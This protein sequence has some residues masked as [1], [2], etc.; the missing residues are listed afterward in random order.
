MRLPQVRRSLTC[1]A[2]VGA[3]LP[4]LARADEPPSWVFFADR[5]REP[6]TLSIALEQRTHELAPRALRRRQRVRGDSGVDARDLLPATAYVDAVLA[7]GATL[8]RQSRWLNAI[9]VEA[10][11][12]QR[13]AIAALSAVARVQPVARRS[14]LED[15]RTLGQTHASRSLR[16]DEEMYG[17]AWQQLTA[18]NVPFLHDC[19]LTGEGVVIGVQDSGFSLE[20]IALQGV[21]VLA[22]RDFVMNDEVVAEEPGDA[23]GQHTHGTMVLSTIAGSDPGT[24]MGA[25]PG[26]S[27]LLSKTEDIATEQPFEEDNYVAGLEWLEM[28]GA[29]LFTASLGYLDWYEQSDFDGKTAVTTIAA[30][31]AVAQGLIMFNSIGNS[32]PGPT[33]MG[34]PADAEGVISVG[35]VTLDGVVTEFS[36]RGPTADGRIKPNIVAPGLDVAVAHPYNP[37]EYITAKGTSFSGPLAAGT[38]ALLL[39]AFPDATPAQ[40]RA[41]LQDAGSR[42]DAPDNDYG[43]GIPDASLPVFLMCTCTDADS[44]G[45]YAVDCGGD[46][47]DDTSAVVRPGAAEICDGRDNNCDTILPPNELD[48]DGDGALACDDCDDADPAVSPDHTEVCGDGLDNDCD[49]QVDDPP[50]GDGDGASSDGPTTDN[51]PT[52]DDAPTSD[53]EDSETDPGSDDPAGACACTSSDPRPLV[54]LVPLVLLRRR[55]HQPR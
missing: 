54:L 37:D 55:R 24:Y 26:V 12:A 40:M 46:D 8:R 29:D 45:H 5:G 25:A 49:Q 11:P 16:A 17:F 52:T 35:A 48:A 47:C 28:N 44:D 7:T 4:A 51:A 22:A 18:L 42:A 14:K 6:S 33:T 38:A 41:M 10:T 1:L 13:A 53:P 20:H 3:S 36:S 34:A 2:L 30:D 43:W 15:P 19:G 50:C 9:S 21:T 39:Q 27:V 23:E 31:I 32:G